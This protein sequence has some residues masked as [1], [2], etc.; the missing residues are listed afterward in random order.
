MT[1]QMDKSM[2]GLSQEVTS[3]KTSILVDATKNMT[4]PGAPRTVALSAES[5]NAFYSK[6]TLS[7][8]ASEN[9]SAAMS[10]ATALVNGVCQSWDT[11]T[12]DRA[13]FEDLMQI[14]AE[15]A[16]A[17]GESNRDRLHAF[18][19]ISKLAKDH[20]AQ[21]LVLGADPI[22]YIRSTESAHA[23]RQRIGVGSQS[24]VVVSQGRHDRRL[25]N[26]LQGRCDPALRLSAE[27]FSDSPTMALL[28]R[29]AVV[30]HTAAQRQEAAIEAA[31]PTLLLPID[32]L[33]VHM[34]V[35]VITAIANARHSIDGSLF[36]LNR[37]NVLNAMVHP[38]DFQA[39]QTKV[40]PAYLAANANN[41]ARFVNPTMFTPVDVNYDRVPY[42]GLTPA[43][44]A[45]NTYKTNLLVVN[46]EHDVI[47]LAQ[48]E[49]AV[50]GGHRNFTDSINPSVNLRNVGVS[51]FDPAAP[52]DATKA[53]NFIF[54]VSEISSAFA[55]E[56]FEGDTR[57]VNFNFTTRNLLLSPKNIYKFDA[58]GNRQPASANGAA[59][60][61]MAA[62]IASGTNATP[63][64][65]DDDLRIE[66]GFNLNGH[67]NLQ[68]GAMQIT[69]TKI[70]LRGVTNTNTLKPIRYT[71]SSPEWAAAAAY[72]A[73]AKVQGYDFDATFENLNA[74]EY[75]TKI[76][77]VDMRHYV[78]TNTHPP[79]TAVG[80]VMGTQEGIQPDR[81]QNLQFHA[82]ALQSGRGIEH[83]LNHV[84][85]ADLKYRGETRLEMYPTTTL[86]VASY[87]VNTFYRGFEID[88]KALVSGTTNADV[89]DN[90]RQLIANMVLRW[91]SEADIESRL[92]IWRETC[93]GGQAPAPTVLFI[94][95]P[96]LNPYMF[97]PG[98]TRLLGDRYPFLVHQTYNAAFRGK[99]VMLW[100]DPTN[101]STGGPNMMNHGNTL[102]KAEVILKLPTWREGGTQLELGLAQCYRHVA[103]LPLAAELNVKGID[104]LLTSKVARAV[105]VAGVVDTHVV[106]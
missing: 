36:N 79:I 25:A 86:G 13:N 95:D 64:N 1:Q 30:Y 20:A 7:A 78:E 74:R 9:L 80:P 69:A 60:P 4:S 21:A 34:T 72:M 2:F 63:V 101:N 50:N 89:V 73:G 59:T 91:A 90:F 38:E 3:K 52:T 24:G 5:A 97:T 35:R 62:L 76:D 103:H 32:Q 106:P 14:S 46:D 61:R 56:A 48:P 82:Y 22:A 26:M 33:G 67:L 29:Y 102:S 68:T 70:S 28:A 71:E 47:G 55:Q 37:E 99:I 6:D 85:Q 16:N 27:N 58:D 8:S 42:S 43:E 12:R 39:Q 84:K 41:A 11:L 40:I 15:S 92:Q 23:L 53:E 96:I 75:G 49:Q 31:Y 66:F 44:I 57:L 104:A 19:K 45:A 54:N 77:S 94:I 87:N 88:A 93:Y 98:D 51:F 100:V 81:I 83:V 17:M 105:N 65:I 18:S 10:A